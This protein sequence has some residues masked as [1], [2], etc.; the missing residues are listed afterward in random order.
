MTNAFVVITSSS[1]SSKIARYPLRLLSTNDDFFADFEPNSYNNNNDRPSWSSSSSSS[2]TPRSGDGRSSSSSSSSGRGGRGGGRGGRSSGRSNGR[3][4][5]RGDRTPSRDHERSKERLGPN[6]HDYAPSSDSTGINN[7][8]FTDGEVH[9]MLAERLRAKF[10]RD[11]RTADSI[12]TTLIEGGVFVHDGMKEY[13]TDGVPFD[14]P[15][16][17]LGDAGGRGG[18]VGDGNHRNKRGYVKSIHS[19]S[20]DVSSDG[21]TSSDEL[22]DR[23]VNERTKFK[24]TRQ[25]DK[26]DAV[27]EGLRT[28]FNVYIDDRLM[29]WSVGGDFG[30]ERNAIRE[31]SVAFSERGYIKSTSS[32]TL[33]DDD[34]LDA[35]ETEEYIQHHVDARVTAKKERN[36]DTADKIRL[37]LA[38]RF[39]VTINDKIKMWS[40][41][42][43][44]EEMGGNNKVGKPRGAYTRRGGGDLSLDVLDVISRMLSDRHH[45][46]KQRNYAAADE[47]RDVLMSKYKVS[48][49]DR[50][51]EWRVD[52]NDYAPRDNNDTAKL[53]N[54][55]VQYVDSRLKERFDLK[56]MRSYED[57]D[58]IRDELMTRFGIQIDDRTKEWFVESENVESFV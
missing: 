1:S 36:F 25:Y 57:A 8:R 7:S 15:R 45:A 3:S 39:D 5:G 44:F 51:C 2:T 50:S 14:P 58:A 37:D 35:Q 49:D 27:R 53:S 11:F 24:M 18:G 48:I 20:L 28:K 33:E 30:S 12:R 17:H 13:R 52:T 19:P 42:G 38:Q 4:S 41:G 31:M 22:I 9:A 47:I 21:T 23:L 54:E 43:I 29:E 56:R 16:L 55:I 26:A 40:I 34:E 6:G 32:L 10:A 46:K